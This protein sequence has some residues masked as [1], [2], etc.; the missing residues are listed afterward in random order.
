MGIDVSDHRPRVLNRDILAGDGAD[1]VLT[2]TRAHLPDVVGL[3]AAAWP[4]TFT[5]K[6]LA[7][8]ANSYEP[9]STV[10]GFSGWLARMAEGR[11]ARDM[12]HG[13]PFDDVADPYGLPKRHH[14]H[15]I[16]EVAHQV[17][18]LMQ[19]G[20]WGVTPV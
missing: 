20:P 13:D 7:R 1:L 6:E 19:C 10:E 2:M 17:E 3:D 16:A 14:V 5:L 9:P 11:L 8:R 15:M 18:L 12:L 4:R